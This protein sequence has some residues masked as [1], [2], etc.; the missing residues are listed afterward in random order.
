MT[1]LSI[2]EL[3]ERYIISPDKQHRLFCFVTKYF[4]WQYSLI[5]AL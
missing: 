3:Y 5:T 1:E 4:L 2:I